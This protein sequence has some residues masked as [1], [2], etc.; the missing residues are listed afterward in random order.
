MRSPVSISF[1][2]AATLILFTLSV[3]P[4]HHHEGIPCMLMEHCERGD[5]ANEEHTGHHTATCSD[6]CQS[7]IVD[8][9]Y[10]VSATDGRVKCRIVSLNGKEH[11]RSL[12]SFFPAH[13]LVSNLTSDTPGLPSSKFKHR[14]NKTPLDPSTEINRLNGLRAPPC[15]F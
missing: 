1:L 2:I 12:L 5:G 8:V 13:F 9:A 7:C 3:T 4:H 6:H 15:L 10:T 11:D 14:Q